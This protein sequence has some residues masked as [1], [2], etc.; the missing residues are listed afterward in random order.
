MQ[1]Y[2]LNL[3]NPGGGCNSGRPTKIEH[4]CGEFG[5]DD[6]IFPFYGDDN[7]VK[8]IWKSG[9]LAKDGKPTLLFHPDY[10]DKPTI[11]GSSRSF[12]NFDRKLD[13]RFII[14]L[15]MLPLVIFGMLVFSLEL[16]IYISCLK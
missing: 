5:C 2:E 4:V 14:V 9:E 15:T 12:F 1:Q 10:L 16:I 7:R 11:N 6:L 8:F 3:S 13:V